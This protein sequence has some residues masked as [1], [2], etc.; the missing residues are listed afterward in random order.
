MIGIGNFSCSHLGLDCSGRL[1]RE[2]ITYDPPKI[3]ILCAFH[4]QVVNRIRRILALRLKEQ[5]LRGRLHN[6]NRELCYD[7]MCK[8]RFSSAFLGNMDKAC[9]NVAAHLGLVS[10][11]LDWYERLR[12]RPAVQPGSIRVRR[13]P[14]VVGDPVM[15]WDWEITVL[16]SAQAKRKGPRRT[17]EAKRC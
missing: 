2:H 13:K 5:H 17:R 11:R 4:N 16:D 10:S 15:L 7:L 6:L 3:V 12:S 8:F 9:E 1:E 14:I